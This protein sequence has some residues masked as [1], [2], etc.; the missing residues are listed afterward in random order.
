MP[1]P[2]QLINGNNPP[3]QG[4]GG[5]TPQQI[6]KMISQQK[7]DQ[8][9]PPTYGVPEMDEQI[10]QMP[11]SDK[12]TKTERWIYK[13][14]PGVSTWLEDNE[15]MGHKYSDLLDKFNETWVGKGLQ[16]LDVFA[17]GLERTSGLV[18][19]MKD[20]NFDISELKSAWYAGSLTYDTVNLPQVIDSGDRKG[21]RLPTDMPGAEEGLTDARLKIQQ[22]MKQGYSAKEALKMTRDEYYQGLGALSLRAQLS[23]TAGHILLDPLNLVSGWFKPLQAAKVKNINTLSKI[24]GGALDVITRLDEISNLAK[25]AEN[26][27]DAFGFTQEAFLLSQLTG[28]S[29]DAVRLGEE[30]LDMAKTLG[31]TEDYTRLADEVAELKKISENSDEALAF[32]EKALRELENRKITTSDKVSMFLAGGDPLRPTALGEKLKKIP[33]LGFV[34]KAAELT[35]ASKASELMNRLANNIN[36]NII[37]KLISDPDGAQKF[38]SLMHRI[39]KG[40]TGIEY[41]HG[42][43]SLEGRTIQGFLS[44]SDFELNTLLQ[45]Y[46][47]SETQRNLLKIISDTLGEGAEVVLRRADEN[48][49]ALIDLLKSKQNPILL[50]LMQSGELTEDSLKALYRI[51]PEGVPYNQEMFFASAMDAIETSVMRQAVVQFGVKSKGVLTRWSDAL[52]AAESLAFLRLSAGYVVRNKINNDVTMIARGLFGLMGKA[53]M[54]DLWKSFKV[55]PKR[56][57]EAGLSLEAQGSKGLGGAMKVLDDALT[58]TR[59]TPDKIK[60]FIRDLSLGKLDAVAF[61]QKIESASR[62]KATSIG[63]SQYIRQYFKPKNV[64]E[65]MNPRLANE[66]RDSAPEVESLINQAYRSSGMSD[67]LLDELMEGNL[68]L[69]VDSILDDVTKNTSQ[70]VRQILGAEALEYIHKKLPTAIKE[71]KVDSFKLEMRQ[72]LN[73][74]VEDLFQSQID[75]LVEHVKSQTVAGGHNVFG[76]YLAKSSDIFWDAH[77]EHVSR[78]PE[79][80]QLARQA[81]LAGDYKTAR[82]LWVQEAEDARLFYDRAFRRVDAYIEGLEKGATELG[83]RGADI[84][85]KDIRKTFG[86]WKGMWE[87]FFKEKNKL[88]DDFFKAFDEAPKGQKP[89]F[90]DVLTKNQEM[91]K[92]NITREDALYQKIDDTIANMM[93]IENRPAFMQSRDTLKDMRRVDKEFVSKAYEE[94]SRLPKEQRPAYWNNFHKNRVSRLQQMRQVE[95]DSIAIQQGDVR[96]IQNY[97]YQTP[98]KPSG[99]FDIFTMAN[100]YGISSAS[101]TG[102]R[103][104]QRILNIVNKH[105]E[106]QEVRYTSVKDIPEDVARAAFEA[107]ATPKGIKPKARVNPN[108]IADYKKVIPDPQPLDLSMDYMNYGRIQPL[109]DEVVSSTQAASKR[110][111]TFLKDLPEGVRSE[112]KRIV[113]LMKNDLASER[114][115]AM[116]FGEWRAD[117]ALLNYNRRTN[118]DN[119]LGHIAPFG[120]WT[121]GSMVKWALESIDRPAM[122]TNYLR[123]KKFLATSGLQRDGQASRTK[124]KIRI[125]LPFAPEWMGEQFIDPLRLMLP[126]DNWIAPF[127]QIQNDQA[128]FDGRV[129]R[130]LE[131]ML[132]EGE[133]T[134]EEYENATDSRSGSAWEYAMSVTK[135]NEDGDRYDA[136]DFA[137]ALQAPHA[138][139]MWAYNAAFGDKE[140]IPSF[141]PISRLARNTATILGVEDWNNHEWNLEAK[142]RRQLGLNSYDGWD[143]YRIKRSASNLAGSGELTPQEAK[144]AITYANLVETGK[145]TAEQAKAESEAYKISVARAND[146]FTGGISGYVLNFLGISVTSVPQGENNIRSLQDDFGKAYQSY[147]EANDS[148]EAFIEQNPNMSEEEA[149]QVWQDKNPKLFQNADALTEFFDA[150]PEYE[151]RLALFKKPE[152]QIHAFMVDQIWK[153][154]NELPKVNR[155]EVREHLG[156]PFQMAFLNSDTRSYDDVPTELMAVWLKMMHVDPAGGL[157]AD[158][159]LLVSFYGKVQFTDPEVANRVEVFYDNRN[160]DFPDWYEKQ[161]TYYSFTNKNQRKQYLNQ[162][163]DLKRYF[164]FRS[165]FMIDNPDLVP[166]LTDNQKSIDKAKNQTRTQTAVPTAQEIKINLPPDINELIYTY[167]QNGNTIPPVLLSELEYY[168]QNYNLTG[169]QVYNIVAGGYGQR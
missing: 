147:K 149:A 13:K 67:N 51:F 59:G 97:T 74:H 24:E 143:D 42:F 19:Q 102:T 2:Q 49:K 164:D 169:E 166:Y 129:E 94:V 20:P 107:N 7:Q 112:V 103:N 65:Y 78:M 119:W 46:Q 82:S 141:S 88:Q 41:G 142:V 86:E 70:D 130:T 64:G 38:V 109:L 167:S 68:N 39:K 116:Q 10:D 145:M 44:N 3:V 79:A 89:S 37:S 52:K 27:D 58:G 32:S 31:K 73:Q 81:S 155:D 87:N 118:F 100:D 110:T 72:V 17:E 113:P 156:E 114:Y 76:D 168:G 61:S 69:S 30:A 138:P 111:P 14:L 80:T 150:H 128:S 140:D 98:T 15:I 35:P 106:G 48:P 18:V 47:K 83:K 90:D 160:S 127:D 84:P 50:N 152:E 148:L 163:P 34:A 105:L 132:K 123:V 95:A 93:P 28:N 121:T 162:N 101:K 77:I 104:D 71:R 75:N 135:Q 165:T 120:F 66:L 16:Y 117:S 6:A 91:Y 22:L 63:V 45:T 33:G 57:S 8:Q 36:T 99:E 55:L 25:T 11:N 54:D 56:L 134:Q 43:L 96:A 29:K 62:V 159:R 21:I 4:G 146:E 131:Q 133:I 122:L 136:W 60:E 153:T 108:Y 23:D 115:K 92:A 124:G 144:E 12:L 53:E 125:E 158:Q 161:Q 85:F 157:T 154:Y 5:I 9:H 139:I 40:G 151:S 137:T 126:F 1:T 26:L